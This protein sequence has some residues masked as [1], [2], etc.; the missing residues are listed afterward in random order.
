MATQ[1]SWAKLTILCAHCLK[2]SYLTCRKIPIS[3]KH[4]SIR[5][6]LSFNHLK[7]NYF[8]TRY[9]NNPVCSVC[10]GKYLAST[11]LPWVCT[12]TVKDEG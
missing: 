3:C 1:A 10:L 12:R 2:N 4:E 9:L 8:N 11:S 7:R 5:I 6:Y